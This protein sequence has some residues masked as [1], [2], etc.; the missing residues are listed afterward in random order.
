[1]TSPRPNT[2]H[3]YTDTGSF[4]GSLWMV[5]GAVCF[6]IMGILVKLTGTKFAMHEY[7]LVFWRVIFAVVVLGVQAILMRQ[8][9]ATK[10][11]KEHFWRSLAGTM[12]LLMFFFWIGAT[13]T[14]DC[15]YF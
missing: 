14:S 15:D 9:F 3:N 12:G 7:E 8:A 11:P 4:L 5:V 10:Y 6:T 13:T 1:M 2:Y